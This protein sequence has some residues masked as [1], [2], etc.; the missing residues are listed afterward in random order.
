MITSI[1]IKIFYKTVAFL[2][3]LSTVSNVFICTLS[4]IICINKIATSI[5]RRVN[6]NHLDFPKIGFLQQFQHFQ[7]IALDIEVF[8]GIKVHTF[9]P[10]RAEG[11]VDWCIG[12]KNGLL[13]VRPSE[14]VAFLFAIHHSARNFLHQH[15]LIN[16]TNHFAI[17]VNRFCHSIGEQRRQLFEIFIRLV[18]RVHFEFVHLDFLQFLF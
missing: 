5:I 13:L 3:E 7:I 9:L 17:F 16:G 18:G 15:I 2:I 6:I 14:L 11:F 12:K 1:T 4:K 8:C 10:A